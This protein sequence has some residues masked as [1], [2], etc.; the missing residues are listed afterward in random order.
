MDTLRMVIF[1]TVASLILFFGTGYVGHRLSLLVSLKWRWLL[2]TG[3]GALFVCMPAAFMLMRA[4]TPAFWHQPLYVFGFMTMGLMSLLFAGF[5][6]VDLGRGLLA[7]A[8]R[9][10]ALGSAESLS[11]R[12]LPESPERREVLAKAV[13]YAVAAGAL[14][15]AGW[16][17]RGTRR[18]P[19]V[20]PVDV[21]I[22]NL[23][24]AVDGF[25]IA[26][27]TD[28]HVCPDIGREYVESV[29]R[30]VNSL[31]ADLVVFTGDLADGQ[32]E[33]L[34]ADTEPLSGLR[35]RLGTYFVN[36]NHE[37][38]SDVPGWAARIDELGMRN[39][40]NEH[41]VLDC[42]GAPLV[43]AGVTDPQAKQM[44]DVESP[45]V[46]KALSRAPE[47]A[48]LILLSHNPSMVKHALKSGPDL[49]LCGHTHG[50]QYFPWTGVV[51]ALMPYPCG[52]YREGKTHI[53]TS[54]GTGY[55]GP[56][57]RTNGAGEVTLI[58]LRKGT[59]GGES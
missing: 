52:Y 30:T 51:G 11:R 26:Q 4:R 7:L 25:R 21:P 13:R 58:T 12:L 27:I 47:E 39:L 15:I 33:V 34:R 53:Y 49:I 2:W 5:L 36:G 16:G 3:T 59:A 37:Y 48:T 17:F 56:P 55:W 38:Y 41:V 31:E 50:G 23:P 18:T 46:A 1:A 29:V 22:E 14:A 8:D 6:L 24:P 54:R 44:V 28:L 35:S 40:V 32:V 10:L 42:N 57:I 20:V 45:D 43:L 9:L 19:E